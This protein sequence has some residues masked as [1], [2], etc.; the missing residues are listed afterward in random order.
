MGHAALVTPPGVHGFLRH[1]R[2]CLHLSLNFRCEGI[3]YLPAIEVNQLLFGNY[4]CIRGEVVFFV[5]T[6]LK[7]SNG[8]EWNSY[9]GNSEPHFCQCGPR[10]HILTIIQVFALFLVTNI[11]I[12][13]KISMYR[14]RYFSVPDEA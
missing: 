14:Y 12:C 3:L 4:H 1:L 13:K 8:M 2:I 10:C 6:E 11:R 9:P 5:F 7:S